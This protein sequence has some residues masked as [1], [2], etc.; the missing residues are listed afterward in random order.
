MPDEDKQQ[1]QEGARHRKERDV[2][3]ADTR[4]NDERRK[5]PGPWNPDDKPS[6]GG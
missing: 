3:E 2:T 1:R 5:K 6:G 4:P